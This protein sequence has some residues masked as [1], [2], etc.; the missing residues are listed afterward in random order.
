MIALLRRHLRPYRAQVT[1]VVL[2]LLLQAIGQLWLPSLNADIINKGVLTGDTEYILRIGWLMLGVTVLVGVAA[3][4]GA[5]FSAAAA[6]GFGRDVRAALFRRVQTFSL[7]E[8]NSFGAPSLITRN[9]N[10]VQQVQTFIVIALLLMVSA[11]ITMIGG[12]VMALRENAELS[13]LLLVIVPV[14]VGVIA[15]ILI[16]AVPLFRSVQRKIDVINQILRENLTGIRVV[17]AFVRTRDEEERFATANA[18]LTATTLA[19]TRLFAVTF[20]AM[21]LIINGASVAIVWFGAHLIDAGDLQIGSMTAFLSYVVQILFA[22]LMAIMS[23]VLVPRAAASSE[24]IA[25][26]LGTEPAIV[27][28]GTPTPPRPEATGQV[29]FRDVEFRYPGAEAPVLH[30]ITLRFSP[31]RTTAVVGSTGSG[32]TTLVNLIPR[33]YDVTGGA[34]LVDGVDVRERPLQELWS[35]LGLV[36]QRAFLFS[37]SVAD[38]LRYGNE[39]ATDDEL[40]H[41][42]EVAQARDVVDE[43]PGGLAAVVEQGGANLSGGQRQRLAIARALVRRPAIYIFDDSFSAVDYATDAR[44][45]AALRADTRD[46]TVIIVAQRIS[47]VLGADQIVVLDEGTV[48]GVGTHEQLLSTCPTYAEIVA[49]QLQANEAAA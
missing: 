46:V 5:Y 43:L 34:V 35:R 25:A 24:R 11:P 23:V 26:V 37:G 9:T 31:G 41:A 21:M 6:M 17:R 32:K 44:L 45:R 13:G 14:M 15:I 47:T 49:S 27:D 22:V 39:T 33:L 18:D 10:D 8:V 29:E 36:P 38:N 2:L 12:V 4:V 28:P 42:L 48:V 3:V 1:T 40:W 30:R 20:P 16:R 19:V 7:R